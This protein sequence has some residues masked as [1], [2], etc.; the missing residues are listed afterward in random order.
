MKQIKDGIDWDY[1]NKFDAIEE[2]YLP[3]RGEGDSLATQAVTAVSKI[4]YKWF[5]DGDVYDTTKMSGWA[6]DLSSY[7]NWLASYITGARDILEQ[8][9][10]IRYNDEEQYEQILRQLADYVL[11]EDFLASLEDQSKQGSIYECSGDFVWMPEEE[12]EYE[13]EGWEERYDE[14]DEDGWEEGG[15]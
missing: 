15:W 1:F 14:Q 2:E 8:V 10:D 5:N 13:E 11:N 3:S 6:N 12:D 4:I 9:W 7:A